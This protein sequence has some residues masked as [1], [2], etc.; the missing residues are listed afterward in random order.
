[1][2]RKITALNKKIILCIITLLLKAVIHN[3]IKIIDVRK[4]DK[5][6]YLNLEWKQRR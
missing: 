1:M 3:E 6:V 2:K 4:T 5:K